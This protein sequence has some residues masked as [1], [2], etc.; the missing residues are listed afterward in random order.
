M[1]F[2][3]NRLFFGS[4]SEPRNRYEMNSIGAA[5]GFVKSLIPNEPP[6]CGI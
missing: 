3:N 6:V 4:V 1:P 5:L 2:G